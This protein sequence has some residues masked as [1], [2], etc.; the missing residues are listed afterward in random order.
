MCEAVIEPYL[1]PRNISVPRLGYLHKVYE[2]A[3]RDVTDPGRSDEMGLSVKIMVHRYLH[4]IAG[5]MSTARE[6][7]LGRGQMSDW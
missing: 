7:N 6:Q 3:E 5:Q 1:A 4:E 2:N